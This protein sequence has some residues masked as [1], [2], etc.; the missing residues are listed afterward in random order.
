MSAMTFVIRTD[1]HHG[2]LSPLL[3]GIRGPMRALQRLPRSWR[4]WKTF[5]KEWRCH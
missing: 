4:S 2:S 1:F 3:C 5:A